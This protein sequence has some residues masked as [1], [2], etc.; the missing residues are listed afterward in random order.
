MKPLIVITQPY[1]PA[2][3]VPLF[4]EV[5]RQLEAENLDLKVV[6]ARPTGIQS[7]RGDRASG[8]WHAE[9]S[10]RDIPIAKWSVTLRRLPEAAKRAALVVSELEALNAL[11]WTETFRKRPTVLWGH[12][13]GFVNKAGALSDRV[14]SLLASRA[15][16]VMTYSEGGRRFLLSSGRIRP[17]SVTAIGNSTN[18]AVI[19]AYTE[20]ALSVGWVAPPGPHALYVGGLDRSKRVPFLLQAF[21]AGRKV[22]PSLRLT[23]VGKGAD[24]PLVREAASTTPQ[25][26]YVPEARDESLAALGL[27]STMM[28]IPGRVGL[29]AV[30]ALAMGLPVHTTNFEY[31]APEI[32]FLRDDEVER[33]GPSPAEF[34]E[35]SLRVYR[36]APK[37][38][39]L[40]ED[41]PTVQSVAS[42]MVTVITRTL[43]RG[44]SWA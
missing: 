5:A 44:Q 12:G 2:Y 1:V 21:E 27:E 6:S 17:D 38:R 22:D 43:G 8:V 23:V 20:Q 31:H 24:E 36:E 13:K 3:R 32:E 4:D 33:L 19:R 10:A 30:D 14:E 16:H 28:W 7:A 41:I 39:A 11:G 15:D 18:S 42:S 25:L 26:R 29:V 34:A 40:R 9:I 35:Q 37:L